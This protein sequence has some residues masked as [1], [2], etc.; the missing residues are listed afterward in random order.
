FVPSEDG[1]LYRWNLAENALAEVINLGP[2]FGEPYVPTV[3]GP[4]GIVYTL[5]GGTLFAVGGLSNVAVAIYS[6]SPDLRSLVAGQPVTFTAVVTNLDSSGP[7]PTGKVTFK[8]LTYWN[9]HP[10]T[11]TLAAALTLTNGMAAVTTSSL[12]SR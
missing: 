1:R 4:D 12:I 6:S 9:V 3:I 7:V 8:D 10:V 2:G 11:N 5:N